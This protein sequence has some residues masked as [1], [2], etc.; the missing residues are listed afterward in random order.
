M[1]DRSFSSCPAGWRQALPW[2]L[3]SG[4]V[5]AVTLVLAEGPLSDRHTIDRTVLVDAGVVSALAVVGS[6]ALAARLRNG[7]EEH[8][9]KAP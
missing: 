3:L 6:T 5:V 2:G 9:G 8:D 4:V 1:S 7:R